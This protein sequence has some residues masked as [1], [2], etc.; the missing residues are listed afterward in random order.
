MLSTNLRWLHA[1][2]EGWFAPLDVVRLQIIFAEVTFFADL[3]EPPAGQLD[4]TE[5]GRLMLALVGLSLLGLV[6]VAMIYL[7]GRMTRRIARQRPIER[8]RPQS[9]WD[10]KD[11]GTN[12]NSA[13]S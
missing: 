6:L 13:E 3:P 11:H 10:R 9:D 12:D 8:A 7:G 1:I 2:V 5:R 4:E